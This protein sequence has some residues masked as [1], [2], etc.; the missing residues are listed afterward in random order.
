MAY[1]V[2]CYLIRNVFYKVR[3]MGIS[4]ERIDLKAGDLSLR[5]IYAK[6]CIVYKIQIVKGNHHAIYNP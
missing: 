3:S 5:I 2:N 4:V 6:L 1:P